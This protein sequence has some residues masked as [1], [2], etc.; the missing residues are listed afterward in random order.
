MQFTHRILNNSK[1]SSLTEH[2]LTLGHIID[3]TATP[4][5]LPSVYNYDNMGLAAKIL[6]AWAAITMYGKHKENKAKRADP[7][8]HDRLVDNICGKP[9]SYYDQAY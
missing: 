8:A 2:L 5:Q 1:G 3:P 4:L 9:K 7:A 6:V